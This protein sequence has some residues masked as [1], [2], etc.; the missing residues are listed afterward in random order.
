MKS[1]PGFCLR[2]RIPTRKACP[3]ARAA[4][5][6]VPRYIMLARSWIQWLHRACQA[7]R[8]TVR[9]RKQWPRGFRP[10]VES[11]ERRLTPVTVNLMPSADNTLYQD[12]AGQ[13]SDGAGQHLYVGA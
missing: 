1:A 9:P 12:S 13:L 7:L 6:F 5:L 2:L 10:W 11:L 4:V 3:F 8:G